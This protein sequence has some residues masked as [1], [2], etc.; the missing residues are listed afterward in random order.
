MKKR[1]PSPLFDVGR[2][3]A[4][5]GRSIA[6]LLAGGM[7]AS[8]MA[9]CG[10]E[11][12][13]TS[14]PPGSGQAPAAA[15][16]GAPGAQPAQQGDAGAADGGRNPTANL[17]PLPQREFKERDFVETENNRDPF[18]SFANDKRTKPPIVLQRRVL[19][20]RYA[21]EELKL[22]GIVTRAQAR[23]LLTDPSGL[24][25]VAKIGDYV[26][27]A[28]IV[29]AGGPSG[30]DVPLNWRVDRIRDSDVVFVRDDPSHPEIPPATRV[31]ALRVDEG[32]GQNRGSK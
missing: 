16:P 29:H 17:P 22:V 28:E 2:D 21:L 30:T 10:S 26:G 5:A 27:K 13:Y 6:L 15:A 23:A 20:D 4:F 19:V 8:L 31:I 25:W 3:S 9:G 1:S 12:V 14:P 11:P 7:G 18:R 24:G 32:A